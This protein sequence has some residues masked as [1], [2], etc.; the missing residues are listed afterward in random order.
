MAIEP[1]L[2]LFSVSAYPLSCL[3]KQKL[4][5]RK[6]ITLKAKQDMMAQE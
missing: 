3:I 6:F 5:K 2:M 1:Y 4:Q